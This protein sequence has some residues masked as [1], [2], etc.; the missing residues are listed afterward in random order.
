MSGPATPRDSVAELCQRAL[1]LAL[2]RDGKAAFELLEGAMA[3]ADDSPRSTEDDLRR[4]ADTLFILGRWTGDYARG[5]TA[6]RLLV[7]RSDSPATRG[8]ITVRMSHLA[9]AVGPRQ[10]EEL[11]RAALGDFTAAG[12]DAGQAM[13]ML[14]MAFPS[15]DL[16]PSARFRLG[17]VDA[18]REVGERLGDPV[19][20]ARATHVRAALLTYVGDMDGAD[21]A[22]RQ[23]WEPFHVGSA[24]LSS[25]A[26]AAVVN[27]CLCLLSWGRFREVDDVLERSRH[28]VSG[29]RTQDWCQLVRAA[30][31][32]H[33]GRFRAA[34]DIIDSMPETSTEVA[35]FAA[36][37]RVATDLELSAKV[38]DV[39]LAEET[40]YLEGASMQ[41]GWLARGVQA[42]LRSVRCDPRPHRD[43]GPALRRLT[44]SQPRF[45]WDSLAI[46]LAVL[47]PDEAEAT[48]AD[49]W[50]FWP[51]GPGPAIRRLFVE[52][53]LGHHEGYSAFTE[54]ADRYE[55]SEEFPAAARAMVHA[56]RV[57]P[58]GA[59]SLAAHRRALDLYGRTDAARSLATLLRERRT[60]REPG[61]PTIP[62]SQRHA[63]NTGL[64]PRERQVAELAVEGLTGREIAE[65]LGLSVGTVRNHLQHARDKMGG[66]SKR[67][68]TRFR[69]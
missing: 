9:S 23:V 26:S 20:L 47:A 32:L 17:L 6:L 45:G 54:V 28:L 31:H 5:E 19:I 46:S 42:Y 48:L 8:W 44:P 2:R 27:N 24:M 34:R 33:R 18:A 68:L 41:L 52:T 64:T 66:L 57:A 60:R 37:L 21:L 51:A 29:P 4:L 11:V 50:T 22:Y 49:M 36:V 7:G 56:A 14:D 16:L 12:D 67:D 35:A 39:D 53:L 58:S 63:V 1:A 62:E 65:R 25:E 15:S 10:E 61:S 59:Q 43:I 13:S 55:A 69:S 3:G 40:A 30:A 38:P